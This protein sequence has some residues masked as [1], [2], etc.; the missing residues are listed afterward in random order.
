MTQITLK[1]R[2]STESNK[3]EIL[4]FGEDPQMRSQNQRRAIVRMMMKVADTTSVSVLAIYTAKH[5][6]AN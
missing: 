1:T 5:F 4:R 6:H 3:A 2:K